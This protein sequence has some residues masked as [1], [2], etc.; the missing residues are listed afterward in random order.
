MPLS[1]I[2]CRLK[3]IKLLQQTTNISTIRRATGHRRDFIR[4]VRDSF[5]NDDNI[6][7]LKNTF[8]ALIKVVTDICSELASLTTSNRRMLANQL[9]SLISVN[10]TI[11]D[12]FN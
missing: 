11:I 5:Q 8:G 1:M 4:S 9:A 6:F 2:T 3:I 10:F 12:V 7:Q